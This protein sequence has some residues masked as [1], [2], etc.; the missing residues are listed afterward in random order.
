MM[1]YWNHE[2][3]IPGLHGLVVA[4][5]EGFW[6]PPVQPIAAPIKSGAPVP[7]PLNPVWRGAKPALPPRARLF[8][9]LL[10]GRRRALP[11]AL[12]KNSAPQFEACRWRRI[13]RPN[14]NRRRGHPMQDEPCILQARLKPIQQA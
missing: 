3:L 5:R 1:F 6:G 14:G 2:G 13:R 11:Q 10:S 7:K 8:D 12:F 9:N 4:R